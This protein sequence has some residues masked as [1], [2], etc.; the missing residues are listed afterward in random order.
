MKR[1][2]LVRYLEGCGCK[3]EREGSR[4]LNLLQSQKWQEDF[5]AQASGNR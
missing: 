1:G 5:G 2:D 3:L 4:G